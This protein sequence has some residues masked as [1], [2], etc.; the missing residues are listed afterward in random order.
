MPARNCR[1]SGRPIFPASRI[2]RTGLWFALR[3][4]MCSIASLS[5]RSPLPGSLE[6]PLAAEECDVIVIGAGH[7]ALACAAYLTRAGLAVT[8]LEARERI[9]GGTQTE[10]LTLPG[11]LHDTFSTGHP[12]LT[13]NPLFSGDELGIIRNGLSYVGNDPVLVVPFPDGESVTFWC[14]AERTAAEFARYSRRDG[15]AWLEFLKEWQGMRR[16]HFARLTNAPRDIDA[17]TGSE[18]EARYL[19]LR[20]R[21]GFD[22]VCNMFESDHVRGAL[23]WFGMVMVQPIDQP[24]T[25][26]MPLAVPAEWVSGWINPIG[27]SVRLAE[28]LADVVRSGGG[29][30]VT[31]APVERIVV[32]NGRAAGVVTDDGAVYRARRAIVSSMHFT[33]LPEKLPGSLPAPFVERTET[34]RA[35]PSLLVVHLAVN[36]NVRARSVSGPIGAVL[37]GQS[38]VDGV[39]RNLLDIA[40]GRLTTERPWIFSACSTWI[41]PSRAPEGKG[42]V[43][44]IGMVPYALDGDPANWD[45]AKESHADLLLAEY[46]KLVVNYTPGDELGRSVFSPVDIERVNPGFFRGGPQGGDFLPDQMGVNRPVMGWADYRLPVPGLYQTGASTHP[47][48]T[49]SAWP[50][51]HAARAVLEDLQID[52]RMVLSGERPEAAPLIPV[53]D[54]S[55]V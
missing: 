7:N 20:D 26:I 37:T 31:K 19:T 30:I 44:V 3:I 39:A 5:T 36:E 38:T 27:G 35:G 29:R 11:F 32:E 34:W 15:E 53:I 9:G 10:E 49:V 52:W 4:A 45:A 14:D 50:G 51:R 12:F 16:E 55:R 21:S 22:V 6:V 47:G 17:H 28:A 54:T 40:N 33:S 23:L 18:Q 1:E 48:G 43:K 42:V 8:V 24:G 41:D 25:G 2:E 46:A 13:S